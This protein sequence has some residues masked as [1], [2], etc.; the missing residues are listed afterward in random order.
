MFD[1]QRYVFKQGFKNSYYKNGAK[2]GF[3]ADG[4]YLVSI[5][6]LKEVYVWGFRN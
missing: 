3:S 5:S 1:G 4:K 6:S 2:L